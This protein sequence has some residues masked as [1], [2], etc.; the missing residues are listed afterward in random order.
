MD[1]NNERL[2]DR[3]RDSS[4]PVGLLMALP[5]LMEGLVINDADALS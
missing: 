2:E 4:L 3:E 1:G 5:L